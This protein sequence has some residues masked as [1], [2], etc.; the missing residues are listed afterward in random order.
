MKFK[1]VTT[2]TFRT[3][4]CDLYKKIWMMTCFLQENKMDKH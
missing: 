3:V 1:L 4:P 2:E